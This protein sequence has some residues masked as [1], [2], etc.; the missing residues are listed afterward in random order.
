MQELDKIKRVL[1]KHEIGLPDEKILIL[2]ATIG[3]NTIKQVELFHK[4]IGLTGLII[5]KMDGSAKAGV[6]VCIGN[7]FG[8]PIL[9]IG[10]G[11][12]VEDL[13]PFIAKDFA[14]AMFN[15]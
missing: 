4:L 15:D 13:Q 1:Q 3:Q 10:V 7:T 12:Q 6:A 14:K 9:N 2:D 8:I 5:T 11:E